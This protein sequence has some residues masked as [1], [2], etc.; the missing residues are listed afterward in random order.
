MI[1]QCGSRL[2]AL[3]GKKS[4]VFVEYVVSSFKGYLAQRMLMENSMVLVSNRNSESLKEK[5]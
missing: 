2:I 5:I 3:N 1:H 4:R